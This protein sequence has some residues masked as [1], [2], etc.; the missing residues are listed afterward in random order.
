MNFL[1]FLQQ[2][3]MLYFIA[4]IGYIATITKIFKKNSDQVFMQLILYVT[5]PSL[6]IHSMNFTLSHSL[7]NHL[8]TL[9]LLSVLALAV[10][11][12]IA[13]LLN[14]LLQINSF[15]AGVFQSLII[16]G[17][18]GFI[19]YAT[20]YL[21]FGE[22]GIFYGAIFNIPY[23]LFIWTYGFYVIAEEK[24]K[25]SFKQLFVNPGI[26]A[27][28]IGILLLFSPFQLHPILSNTLE[29][30]GMMTIP[31]SMLT[32]GSIIGSLKLKEILILCT[33]KNLWIALVN[34]LLVVPLFLFPFIF[35]GFPP[36]VI[37]VAI[38]LSSMPSGPTT[39]I[40]A[41]KYQV[42]KQFATAGVAMSTVFSML[43]IP[44]VYLLIT[45]LI[46]F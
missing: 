32:I 4:L 30:V 34:K 20:L 22:L 19:G 14:K 35:V 40:V 12:W 39:I 25:P 41:E 45:F 43:T 2:F 18:Q 1:L 46:S 5:L 13:S 29:S 10:A 23:L 36:P 17:N 37:I 8:I 42:D 15:Q 3:S 26:I 21:V 33:N 38:L 44:L 28:L 24:M 9:L 7:T 31:L 16:F 27:T 11:T 6:I